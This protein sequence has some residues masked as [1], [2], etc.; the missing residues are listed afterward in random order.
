MLQAVAMNQVNDCFIDDGTGAYPS[1][2]GTINKNQVHSDW[3][4]SNGPASSVPPAIRSTGTLVSSPNATAVFAADG[5]FTNKQALKI[6]LPSGGFVTPTK[7][8]NVPIWVI[9][10]GVYTNGA[11][12]ANDTLPVTG[13]ARK[14]VA[15][16]SFGVITLSDNSTIDPRT[17]ASGTDY[18]RV[19]SGVGAK[20]VSGSFVAP[21]TGGKGDVTC[22]AYY[23]NATSTWRMLFKRQ[24]N[25][26]DVYDADFS[27][28]KDTPF[29][30]GA[31][32]MGANFQHAIVAGL[33]L[34]FQ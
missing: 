19:G 3:Q 2:S 4:A 34:H 10:S 24:L 13:A 22:N 18:Q 32:L 20:S 16:D 33:T 27:A 26:G 15:V 17:A 29:G 8:A 1:T 14:V 30:I 28:L 31:M 21:Y 23:D 25:T 11:I 5:G 12:Y 6:S 9:P 7:R